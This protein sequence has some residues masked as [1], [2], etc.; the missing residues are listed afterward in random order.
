[1]VK[2]NNS[3]EYSCESHLESTSP[4]HSPVDTP[5]KS[6]VQSAGTTPE[7]SNNNVLPAHGTILPLQGPLA[8]TPTSNVDVAIHEHKG[9][10]FS[11]ANSTHNRKRLCE[12]LQRYRT[13]HEKSSRNLSEMDNDHEDD[14][15]LDSYGMPKYVER[16][17][18]GSVSKPGVSKQQYINDPDFYVPWNLRQPGHSKRFTF[19]DF[20]RLPQFWK[21]FEFAMRITLFAALIPALFMTIPALPN[22]F[23]SYFFVFSSM[24]LASRVFVGESLSYLF[25]WV[26]AG[27]FW[28][29]LT[30]IAAAL[31]LGNNTGWWCAYYTFFLFIMALFTEDISR[32][33]CL[34]LFNICMV[35]LLM[36]KKRD[37][38]YPCRV[39][40][41]WCIGIFLCTIST[42]I[43]YPKFCYY[44]AENLIL[45]IAKTAGNTFQ[46]IMHSFWSES[47]VERNMAM[48]RVRVLAESLNEKLA[49]LE[50]CQSLT[51][52]EFFAESSEAHQIRALKFIL[53]ERLCVNISTL[54]RVLST[55]E[56]NPTVV[57][58]SDRS[59]AFKKIIAP[60]LSAVSSSFDNFM[61][62][63][64]F[65]KS[66]SAIEKLK[67]SFDS[68]YECTSGLQEAFTVARRMFLYEYTYDTMEAFLPLMVSFLFTLVSFSDTAGMFQK[69]VEELNPYF[70]DSLRTLFRTIV[71]EPFCNNL[72]FLKKLFLTG[73]RREVQRVFEAAKVSG[74]MILTIGF[75][76]LMDIDS[77]FFSGPN[78]IAFVSGM[79]PVESVQASIVRLTGCLIG[80]VLGF[81]AGAYS[82]TDA[83]RVSLLCVLI[84]FCTF[85]RNDKDYGIMS[86]YAMFVL[87]PLDS[88]NKPTLK[89]TMDRMNQNTVG[90]FIYL[91]VSILILPLSPSVILRAKRINILKRIN[92]A[93]GS[94][95]DLFSDPF[96]ET[97]ADDDSNMRCP[98]P[99]H[100]IVNIASKTGAPVH[101]SKSTPSPDN[102]LHI[103]QTYDTQLS[104]I[105][106]ILDD[107]NHRIKASKPYV[108]FSK[109]ERGLVEVDYPVG[110]CAETYEHMRIMLV[111]LRAMWMSWSLFRSQRLY[112]KEMR[113]LMVHLQPV[114][115]SISNSFSRIT[116]LIIYSIQNPTTNLE[117]EIMKSVLNLLESCK[118]LQARMNQILVIII[119]EA[120]EEF[121]DPATVSV[122][123]TQL[124]KNGVYLSPEDATFSPTTRNFLKG[125]D[126]FLHTAV[127][128]Q[129]PKGEVHR[130][131]ISNQ[132]R[133]HHL[134]LPL[135]NLRTNGSDTN[136]TKVRSSRYDISEESGMDVLRRGAS[137]R[138]Q[139]EGTHVPVHLPEDFKF[140]ISSED[141][142]CLHSFA[143]S[144]LMFAN[145]TKMLMTSLQVMTD[146]ARSKK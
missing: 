62:G 42:F 133:L 145:E 75:T 99:A 54:L 80:T 60:Q 95:L 104:K 65:A 31:D 127:S 143:L 25:S 40:A 106:T 47:N 85:F 34:L 135:S 141:A 53:F 35:T 116:N 52:Y 27:L 78:I 123:L 86:V 93:L 6:N 68:V 71:Y 87:I 115:A 138:K 12:P 33:I 112:T 102:S 19:F 48:S 134:S 142:E 17:H 144:L 119:A 26:R 18:D 30:V 128:L 24:A 61:T 137:S 28:L 131:Y 111:L 11:E 59:Q 15:S 55:V 13:D 73:N 79:N 136:R 125:A 38:I 46:G 23:V 129:F 84:F 103:I 57:D 76:F 9:T 37:L 132:Y 64:A 97:I 126:D 109:E 92:E 74:A 43:P 105:T 101:G 139:R 90:I 120:V 89:E 16:Y 113:R 2:S 118:E 7:V 72:I 3:A 36:R 29:P 69:D 41:D 107:I 1:M 117:G 22:P 44:R 10:H 140:P 5:Q 49:D 66:K 82:K 91:L 14:V 51:I 100:E 130:K 20:L 146:H 122:P 77:A 67:P 21:Q 39:M 56:N 8:S 98:Q 81:F 121:R 63:L 58:D 45:Q 108:N 70:V 96:I 83:E 110:A 88:I 94:V 124:L 50:N 32:R 4:K 114:A